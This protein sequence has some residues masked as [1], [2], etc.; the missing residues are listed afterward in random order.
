M[1]GNTPVKTLPLLFVAAAATCI[2]M[3]QNA[4]AQPKFEVAS[5]RRANQC[6][7]HNSLDPG[8]V[9]FRGTPLKAILTE[10][11]RVKMDQIEGPYWLITDCYDISAKI[12]ADTSKDQL[13]AM[14]QALLAERFQLA[15]HKEGRQV[16][17]YALVVDKG[18]PKFKPDDPN[19]SFMGKDARPGL[20]F[21]GGYGRGALK[22]VMTMAVLASNF[23]T[24]GYGPVQDLTGLTGRYD[25]DLTWTPERAF[26]P[27]AAYAPAAAATP[28][29]AEIPAPEPNLFAAV[30]QSLG[31]KM[32][33]RNVQ[34]Q[35]VVIDRIERIPTGN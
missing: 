28:P 6:G 33:R 23:S 8:S 29:V 1:R 14:L 17:G 20:T 12:P 18:G 22:G 32:E 10:A 31:L 4:P 19:T 13:P 25:I 3:A 27:G 24:Q 9:T 26:E 16:P 34:V 30:R 35:F 15:A 21:Y 5:V 11:F 2:A 7:G